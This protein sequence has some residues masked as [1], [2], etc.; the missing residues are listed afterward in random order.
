MPPTRRN[1]TKFAHH[2][3]QSRWVR[4]PFYSLYCRCNEVEPR[5]EPRKGHFWQVYA[6]RVSET[7]R[8][9]AD[10]APTPESKSVPLHSAVPYG[11]NSRTNCRMHWFTARLSFFPTVCSFVAAY[12]QNVAGRQSLYG[13]N[14]RKCNIGAAGLEGISACLRLQ[15]RHQILR[16]VCWWP[17]PRTSDRAGAPR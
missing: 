14:S 15:E 16:P 6:P 13:F 5:A 11:E 7:I 9:V 4:E 1:C 10:R 17:K 3:R 12:S 8:I 2:L